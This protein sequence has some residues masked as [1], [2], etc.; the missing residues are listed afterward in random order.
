MKRIKV[1]LGGYVNF[2][3]AQNI[4]CRALSEH[5][6]KG[7]FEISTMLYPIQN[8]KDFTSTEGVRYIRLIRPI[9]FFRY[10]SYLRGIA[11]ADVAYL[12][13]GEINRFCL[14]IARLFNTK[15]FRTLEGTLD[16]ILEK[17]IG[18]SQFPNYIAD[19]RK[20]EPNLF[21]ITHFL[22]KSEKQ[23][24]NL[25]LREKIL[26]LGV[27]SEAFVLPNRSF[28]GQLKNI[29]FIGNDLIRKNIDDYLEVAKA[30]P[31]I[32]FHI[33]GGNLLKSQTIQDYISE[34]HIQNITYHGR[35]DHSELSKLLS[36]MNLMYFPSR[37]EG[38]P[39]VHLEA[40][41]AG[42]PTL[43]Y[44]D[45]GAD[46]WITS[47]KNGIIVNNKDEADAMIKYLQANPDELKKLSEGAVEL[48][49]SFD[50]SVLVK[51]WEKVIIKIC[52]KPD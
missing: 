42:V 6:D 3:N 25:N 20:Y 50:W 31:K 35:L 22:R 12:P 41:C 13:K 24:H 30:F 33:V 52:G 38:F 2:L 43:C 26:Y 1:F 10:L 17:Q 47:G 15:V 19:F 36:I 8:A 48:G 29:I 45:Y 7:R 49:K 28:N 9:R 37:S 27:N 5:L 14:I 4:N 46:E 16:N 39:K 51:E 40:A 11:H 32:I 18:Q 21:P 44:G 34:N 23:R